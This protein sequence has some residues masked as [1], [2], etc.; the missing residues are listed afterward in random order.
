M[1]VVV[2][3]ITALLS[4]LVFAFPA[5][6]KHNY[7]LALLSVCGAVSVY[8]ASQAFI[9][10][11]PL[12]TTLG[13]NVVFGELSF[14]MDRL[15]A[16]FVL[17]ISLA[18][19]AVGI[20]SKGY[21]R[22]YVEEKTPQHMSL[23]LVS[24]VSLYV[25]MLFV[26]MA[27]DAFSFLFAWEM[28]TV[29]SFVLILFDAEKREVRRAAISYVILMHV[30][31]IFLVAGFTIVS[32]AGL[33][34]SFDSLALYFA[35]HKPLPL[36]IVFLI[37][38]GMKAG[39][40]PL[41]IWL[42]EAHP[43]APS[44]V[45]AFMSGVMIKMG[46]YGVMRVTSFMETDVFTIGIVLFVTGIV[47]GLYGA[48]M[49]AVQNDMKRLL[50]YS[51]IENVGIIFLAMGASAIGYA[52]GDNFLALCAMSGALLHTLNHSFFKTLLFFG[53]GN[54]YTAAHTTSL[55]ALGG[56]SRK[57]PVTAVL[58]LLGVMAI[59]ALPPF[60]GFVSEF[61]I[62]YG[63]FDSV[64]SGT[65]SII[66]AMCGIVALS[67]IGGIVLLAFTKLFGVTFLGSPRSHAVEHAEEVPMS[68]LA[69]CILP[70]GGILLVGLAP[71]LFTDGMFS[72]AG[73][74][75][76]IDDAPALYDNL[77]GQVWKM[78]SVAVMLIGTVV[79]LLVFRRLKL[80]DKTV[81]RSPVWGCGFTSP[82]HKM[83][84][85]GESFSEGLYGISTPVTKTTTG[86]NV[87]NKNEIFPKKHSFDLKHKD[88]VSVLL[89]RW[90]VEFM[91]RINLR[92]SKLNTGK[93]NHYVMYA[94]IFL[95]LI[96]ILS[97]TGLI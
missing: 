15:S 82:S 40:F 75:L 70:A 27:R 68:R 56:L 30:G 34:P 63:L 13:T 53:A 42:P 11:I 44:H 5:K 90:W 96:L 67:L 33:P 48:V 92:I 78:A 26:V 55:N 73:E 79:L 2:L 84:Y 22:N 20:Y 97:L 49:A 60:N 54:V 57:M 80:R 1:F 10:G 69:A 76:F 19:V 36:F 83:Q 86:S 21:L 58:F 65:G 61:L 72:V 66:A 43:A 62:Y 17:M 52:T 12:E 4:P 71:F 50:A 46:V 74:F 25:S 3:I 32:S 39:V 93:V 85:S 77:D 89:S 91:K 31:F 29:S 28:M 18:A 6:A 9:T 64:G 45:S 16:V 88:K 35:T 59:S 14:R 7:I 24:L 41:H 51:S 94:L 23:H 37:G 47:T 38:F 8:Y 95:A 87:V 81:E